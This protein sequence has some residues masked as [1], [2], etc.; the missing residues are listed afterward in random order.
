M[1][2]LN[3]RIHQWLVVAFSDV[4]NLDEEEVDP[5]EL[6]NWIQNICKNCPIDSSEGLSIKAIEIHN[7]DDFDELKLIKAHLD[8][9]IAGHLGRAKT[10]DLIKSNHQWQA[11]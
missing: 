1:E 6:R 10:L 4:V 8:S 7:K 3:K 9:P 11:M 5:R 2:N